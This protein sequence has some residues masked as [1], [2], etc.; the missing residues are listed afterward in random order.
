MGFDTW[1]LGKYTVCGSVPADFCIV[2]DSFAWTRPYVCIMP[3]ALSFIEERTGMSGVA[4]SKGGAR[5]L[6]GDY[7][8][9]L[10]NLLSGN[11]CSY[12]LIVAM[13]NDIYKLGAR[14]VEYYEMYAV[15]MERLK[16]FGNIG[17]VFGGSSRV[18]QYDRPGLYDYHVQQVCAV[19]STCVPYV[20]SGEVDLVGLQIAD[21]I[22]HAR[23]SSCSILFES[24]SSWVT[25][26]VR[27]YP[28]ARL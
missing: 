14:S 9:M 20:T 25:A 15:A 1:N 24:F 13:G 4:I 5:I 18:W 19:C 6:A 22:G 11:A 2:V 7:E 17:L 3:L 26:L 12:L 10:E 28:R 16:R 21:R 23:T 27:S 8:Q